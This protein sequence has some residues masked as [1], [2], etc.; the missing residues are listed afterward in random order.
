LYKPISSP[1]IFITCVGVQLVA[2]DIPVPGR[3]FVSAKN[4]VELRPKLHPYI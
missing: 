2:A 1:Y 4:V 3:T